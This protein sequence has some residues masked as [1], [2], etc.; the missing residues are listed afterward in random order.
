MHNSSPSLKI[1]KSLAAKTDT[2][3]LIALEEQVYNTAYK[4]DNYG[5]EWVD[6]PIVARDMDMDISELRKQLS[7]TRLVEKKDSS[8]SQLLQ[9]L[10]YVKE[11]EI[12]PYEYNAGR[13]DEIILSKRKQELISGLHKDIFNDALDN[14]KL[15][16]IQNEDH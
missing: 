1:I 11:G 7:Q 12:A 6:L 5:N 4:Y 3:S 15:K 14:K 13:I 8:Y 10:E 2:E 16:I 9:V